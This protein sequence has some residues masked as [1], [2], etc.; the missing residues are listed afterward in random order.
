MSG[1]KSRQDK[2]LDYLKSGSQNDL[3][4]IEQYPS[5]DPRDILL[6]SIHSA[7]YDPVKQQRVVDIFNKIGIGGKDKLNDY[8]IEALREQ[9]FPLI[10]YLA[11]KNP[12][13]KCFINDFIAEVKNCKGK[14]YNCIQ[15]AIDKLFKEHIRSKNVGNEFIIMF[16]GVRSDIDCIKL[17]LKIGISNVNMLDDQKYTL[18]GEASRLGL[19]DIVTL[20]LEK[21]ADPNIRGIN[22]MTPLIFAVLTDDRNS[23][24]DI[25]KL[26]LKYGADPNLKDDM[27]RSAISLHPN[28]KNLI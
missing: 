6:V 21:G 14:T 1:Y 19:I 25:I 18:L 22:E 16:G 24:Y 11:D 15:T 17:L 8:F 12:T 9:N 4:R 27:N 5:G 10:L 7:K 28:I 20:L 26:L 23:R 2:V 13:Y 3:V